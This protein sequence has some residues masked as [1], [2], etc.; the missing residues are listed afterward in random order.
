MKKHILNLLIIASC[1]SMMFTGCKKQAEQQ[2]QPVEKVDTV[3]EPKKVE[4]KVEPEEKKYE[5]KKGVY[6]REYEEE[7]ADGIETFK[8]YI[9]F[10][11]DDKGFIISQDDVP[12]T[13][14]DG[15]ITD[16]GGQKY[17]YEMTSDKTLLLNTDGVELEY[18]YSGDTLS[19]DVE[20]EMT[21]N[22]DGTRKVNNREA[23]DSFYYL[24]TSDTI[25]FYS[26]KS[27]VEYAAEGADLD[28]MKAAY[29][30]LKDNTLPILLVRTENAPAEVG[31]EHVLQFIDGKIY[32]IIGTD[33]VT[34]LYK[35]SAVI[36]TSTRVHGGD[37]A[38][39]Y[40]PDSNGELYTFA[41]RMVD[42]R[43]ELY[44]ESGVIEEVSE[45]DFEKIVNESINGDTKEEIKWRPL[46]KAV[47]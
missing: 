38:Y 13:Y 16:E 25:N 33:M 37:E 18:T 34:E 14:S 24:I 12:F 44:D 45:E 30:E 42:G 17:T 22:L 23:A 7:F 40:K 5:F 15:N 46:R 4:A 10:M 3:E 26:E 19:E 27:T 20:D 8:N 1:I 39:Y 11:N 35:N 28:E 32:D 47:K 43:C 21:Y 6:V 36:V 29:V 31:F 41:G 9:Y 2:A